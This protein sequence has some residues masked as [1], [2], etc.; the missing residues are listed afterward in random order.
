MP[1]MNQ[2]TSPHA[3]GSGRLRWF[4]IALVVAAVAAGAVLLVLY[5]GDGSAPGY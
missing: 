1:L 5:G 2:Q 4:A 3:T